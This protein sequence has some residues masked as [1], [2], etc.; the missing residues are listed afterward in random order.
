M[1]S[2]GRPT[3]SVVITTEPGSTLRAKTARACTISGS[4]KAALNSST[5]DRR[6]PASPTSASASAVATAAVTPRRG[7]AAAA[8]APAAASAGTRKRR[9]ASVPAPSPTPSVAAPSSRAKPAALHGLERAAPPLHRLERGGP[10]RPGREAHAGGARVVGRR[11][12]E[13]LRLHALGQAP[14]LSRRRRVVGEERRQA[15]RQRD[16]AGGEL[17]ERGASPRTL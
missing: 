3:S 13:V 8:R 15:E 11:G 14:G 17:A 9:C 12:E 6:Q 2:A 16:G 7:H 10:P 5:C 4:W 1:F